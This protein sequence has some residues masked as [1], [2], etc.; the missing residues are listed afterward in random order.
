MY[1]IRVVKD[2]DRCGNGA[3]YGTEKTSSRLISLAW[4]NFSFVVRETRFCTLEIELLVFS[5]CLLLLNL[6]MCVSFISLYD[7]MAR[8]VLLGMAVAHGMPRFG[9]NLVSLLFILIIPEPVCPHIPLANIRQQRGPSACASQLG[10]CLCAHCDI[11]I[12]W[13]C[14][15]SRVSHYTQSYCRTGQIIGDSLSISSI[16]YID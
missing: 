11:S 9:V 4:E 5:V 8:L 6:T 1:C 7:S 13:I 12:V 10:Q 2:A 3:F 14:Q 16:H 15:S